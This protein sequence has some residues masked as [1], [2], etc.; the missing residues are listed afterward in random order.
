MDDEHGG[1]APGRVGLIWARS[2]NGVIGADGGIPW[3]V[4]EDMAHFR[5]TT[6]GAV[7]VMGRRTWDSVPP[8]FRPLADRRNVVLTRDSTWSAAG[9]E[10]VHDL[11]AFLT[12]AVGA[13]DAVWVI[14]GG[15]VYQAALAAADRLSETIVD[16]DVDGDTHAPE[17]GDGRHTADDSG[18]LES[19]TGVRYRVLDRRRRD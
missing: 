2:R 16:L 18:W 9:A 10:V 8:R 3:R 4:P 7:V 15:Q 12:S 1:G 13:G 17:I 6:A 14:G 11:G 5:A 19:R